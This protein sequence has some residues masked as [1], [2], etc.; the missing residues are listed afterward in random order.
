MARKQRRKLGEIL[1]EWGVV[2]QAS[3][4]EALEH[5]RNQG[6]RIG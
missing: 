3:V 2:S 4:E 6:L 5:A 1:V